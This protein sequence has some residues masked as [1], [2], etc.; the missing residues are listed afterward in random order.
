[1]KKNYKDFNNVSIDQNKN[2]KVLLKIIKLPVQIIIK[3]LIIA[4][5]I[6]FN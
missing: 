4:I 2:I 3:D 6:L 5:K 1:M